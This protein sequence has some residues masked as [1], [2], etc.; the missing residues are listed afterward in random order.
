MAPINSL[1][2][3]AGKRIRVN[4]PIQGAA[5]GALGATP[6]PLPINEVAV[7]LGSG[8][9]DAA[10]LPTGEPLIEFGVARMA[11]N[12]YLLGISSAPLAV[13]MNR[14]VF[15]GLPEG[16]QEIIRAHSGAWFA[17]R[18]IA[19]TTASTARVTADL[20]ADPLRNVVEP[21]ESDLARAAAAFRHVVAAWTDADP[22]NAELL[23]RVEAELAKNS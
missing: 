12:H 17:E 19:D 16:A 15:D 22:R 13:L 21:S 14:E 3:L 5:I 23:A 1:D 4:N 11:A 2:D 8:D 10:A 9:I 7:A 18:Y 6:V 20:R